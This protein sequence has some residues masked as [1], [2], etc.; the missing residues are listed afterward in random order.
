METV[1][2]A[3]WMVA[4]FSTDCIF[5]CITMIS[6]LTDLPPLATL[7]FLALIGVVLIVPMATPRV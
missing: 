4:A 1:W 7:R 3:S 5:P 2:A 6:G